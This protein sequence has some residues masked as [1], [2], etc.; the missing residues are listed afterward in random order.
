[1][2]PFFI[3]RSE[4]HLGSP[5]V[6]CCYDAPRCDE[7]NHIS[8]EL[9]S[10]FYIYPLRLKMNKAQWVA[11]GQWRHY[12]NLC[13]MLQRTNVSAG[14]F[15]PSISWG[16]VKILPLTRSKN[17]NREFRALSRTIWEHQFPPDTARRWM[18]ENRQSVSGCRN[19]WSYRLK[20]IS[21][22]QAKG[23]TT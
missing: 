2:S 18:S 12:H 1:M 17:A 11:V 8:D 5:R 20:W 15:F 4:F 19:E 16:Q 23:R 7:W 14:A 22:I 9:R 10:G 3:L 21:G 13:F 6:A